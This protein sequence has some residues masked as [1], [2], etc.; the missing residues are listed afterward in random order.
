MPSSTPKW[1]AFLL[2]ASLATL[3]T[4]QQSA[5]EGYA[6][7]DSLLLK[8][9]TVV[10]GMIVKNTADAVWIQERYGISKH[11]KSEITRI[12]NTA[13]LGMEFTSAH[14]KGDL[15]SWRVM[16][17]DIR[18]NDSITSLEQIPATA[19]DN[20]LYK[21]VPYLSFRLNEL[22]EM[23]IYGDPDD[24]AAIEFGAYGRQAKNDELRR[25]LRA[26]LA[27]FLTS[28]QEVA[29]IYS[30]PF[31][32]GEKCVDTMCFKIIPVSAPDSYG[33]WWISIFN[34]GKLTASRM[35]D[36]TYA[37]VTRPPSEVIGRGGR[38]IRG[39]WSPADLLDVF[40]ENSQDGPVPI[41][42]FK[43]DKFGEFQLIKKNQ[44]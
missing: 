24:P 36:A 17:N 35:N 23:N 5:A 20:G 2:T 29:A 7:P 43:R 6:T 21:N 34:P 9:G 8:D 22:L 39:T 32:G 31:T 33:G 13:D 41:Q 27:G 4:N 18:N 10:S 14:T 28:R 16:V 1:F 38:L 40:Q 44:N 19:I 3:S 42:G 12:R 30:L 25:T 11:P 26:F 37:M 15:P